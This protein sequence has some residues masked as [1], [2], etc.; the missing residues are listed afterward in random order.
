MPIMITGINTNNAMITKLIDSDPSRIILLFKLESDGV[1]GLVAVG[2][3]KNTS[4]KKV[5]VIADSG[6]FT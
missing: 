5:A 2:F 3:W 4:L 1:Y 6:K